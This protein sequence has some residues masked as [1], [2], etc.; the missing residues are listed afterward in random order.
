M[1]QHLQPRTDPVPRYP[2]P[3][4][5]RSDFYCSC[6]RLPARFDNVPKLIYCHKHL[7]L[8]L[9]AH[10]KLWSAAHRKHLKP[11]QRP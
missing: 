7:A 1:N 9:S 11:I 8:V 10:P 4:C 2:Y 5:D 6:L 3:A